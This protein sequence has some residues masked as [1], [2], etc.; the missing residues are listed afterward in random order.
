MLEAGGAERPHGQV[1]LRRSALRLA[2]DGPLHGTVVS[3]RATP[4][5]VGWWSPSTGVGEV[6][7]VADAARPRAAAPGVGHDVRLVVDLT[8]AA[9]LSRIRPAG[10]TSHRMVSP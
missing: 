10:A 1:A 2:F 6:N 4:E 7:A 8:R 9:R 3:A 5:L